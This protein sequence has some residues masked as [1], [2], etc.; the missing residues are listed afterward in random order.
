MV[1]FDEI[2]HKKAISLDC[3]VNVQGVLQK[4]ISNFEGQYLTFSFNKNRQIY[5]NPIS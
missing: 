4:S 3:N 2:R 5:T 1:G